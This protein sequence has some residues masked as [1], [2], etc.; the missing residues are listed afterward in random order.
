MKPIPRRKFIGQAAL[1]TGAGIISSSFKTYN[2]MAEKTF[3]HH[4]YF[5]LKNPDSKED[6]NK[7]IEGLKKLSK[8]KSIASFHIG[9][10]APTN[11]E[12]IDRSYSVSWCLFFNSAADQDSYQT[13][14]IHLKFIE[15]CSMLW[16]KVV[17]YDSIDI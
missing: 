7:L 10:P 12:V 6:F 8:V 1:V 17:V 4:V 9:R 11:R 15:E 3:I 2:D 14:P 5:W 16:K 13:D